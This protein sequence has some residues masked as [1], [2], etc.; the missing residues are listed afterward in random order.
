[1]RMQVSAKD[2]SD[3]LRETQSVQHRE[4]VEQGSVHWI[5]EPRFDRYGIVRVRPVG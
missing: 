4:Q 1:M 2:A 5:G 3:V